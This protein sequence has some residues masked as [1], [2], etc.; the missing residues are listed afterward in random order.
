MFYITYTLAILCGST[1]SLHALSTAV[2]IRTCYCKS[3]FSR[4]KIIISTQGP[5]VSVQKFHFAF[6]KN[7]HNTRT[8]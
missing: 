7:K 1:V 2:H 6:Y 8:H 3:K 4:T 5:R